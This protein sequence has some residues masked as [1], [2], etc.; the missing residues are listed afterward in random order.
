[1][2]SPDQLFER[3]QLA[4]VAAEQVHSLE[5]QGLWFAKLRF[6]QQ[7]RADFIAQLKDFDVSEGPAAKPVALKLKRDWWDPPLGQEG[8]YWHKGLVTIWSP[9]QDLLVFYVVVDSPT[10]SRG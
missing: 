7:Q 3:M 6:S 8:R 10:S 4:P 1:M 5:Y 9:S 2:G